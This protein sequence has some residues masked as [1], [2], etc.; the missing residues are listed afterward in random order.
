MGFLSPEIRYSIKGPITLLL[1]YSL[2]LFKFS[3]C[4]K[5]LSPKDIL[6]ITFLR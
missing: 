3:W 5:L 1:S 4:F 2:F 6:V